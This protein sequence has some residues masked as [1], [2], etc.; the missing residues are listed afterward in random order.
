MTD[1]M[2][3]FAAGL[4]DDSG[5]VDGLES[6][7]LTS[8]GRP[9]QLRVRALL[10]ALLMLALDDRPL[11]LLG[12][13]R[14]LYRQLCE[15][16]RLALGVIGGA[17][18]RAELLA[19]YRSVR[20][21]FHRITSVLGPQVST[22]VN[23]SNDSNFDSGRERL[24]S[25]VAKLIFSSVRCASVEELSSF[26]GSVGLDATPV[27]LFSRGPSP[28]TGRAAWDQDGGWY[29]REG[30]HRDLPGPGGK[31]PR[32]LFW[33]LDA[34]LATMGRPPGAAATHPNLVLGL[35]LGRPGEDP[36]GSS[37][38]LLTRVRAEGFPARFLGADRGYTQCLPEHFHL[39]VR[40][41]GYSLVS[42]YKASELGRQA[43][44][45]GAVL[46]DGAFCCPA[47]P[48]VLITTTAEYRANHIDEETFQ[49]QIASRAPYRLVRKAGPDDNGYE[50]YSCPALGQHPK[51]CCLA[52]PSSLKAGIGKMPV[53][54]PGPPPRICSQH[55]V[56]IAPDV[57]ARHRQDLLY[58][59]PAWQHTYATYRNGIEGTNGYLKDSAHE[60]LAA[61]GRRR[62]RG[63]RAQSLLCALLVVAG[64]VRKLA[65]FRELV[66]EGRTE[67]V[68]RRAKRRRTSL[69]EYLPTL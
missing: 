64:N 40:A 57:G 13:T 47:I 52:R 26:D 49:S 58:G 37:V 53:T 4:I 42:D 36:G 7:L 43:N 5:V 24:E 32:K 17:S 25:T 65:A 29:V 38:R 21:L 10:V 8:T 51:L 44:S 41:L 2:F 45:G 50:R 48:E 23:Q 12:A 62:V 1:E 9:R 30:D 14:L 31:M 35:V 28:R 6:L 11:H 59:S 34:T 33:A 19:R 15:S 60:A 46:I 69:M 56:T 61:P 16:H 22:G 39:P 27:P 55:S 54:P 63:L 67:E 68:A 3:V 66:A 20:Y 18:S